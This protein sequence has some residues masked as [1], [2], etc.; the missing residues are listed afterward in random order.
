[1]AESKALFLNYPMAHYA[2]DVTIQP[3]N[4]QSGNLSESRLYSSKKNGL[5]GYRIDV[6]V[7]Q[8]GIEIGCSAHEPGSVSEFYI[9]QD[10]RNFQ[11]E[12]LIISRRNQ[13]WQMTVQWKKSFSKYGAFYQTRAIMVLRNLSR[14][15]SNQNPRNGVLSPARVFQN[16]HFSERLGPRGKLPRQD[17]LNLECRR[18]KIEMG[19]KIYDSIFMLCMCLTNWQVR[20]NTCRVED[21]RFY[22][23]IPFTGTRL[24]QVN[25]INPNAYKRSTVRKR[26]GRVDLRFHA[27]QMT[28]SEEQVVCYIA[29]IRKAS[30]LQEIL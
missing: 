23:N 14:L 29:I 9:F 17:V 28:E 21:G 24:V 11:K 8:N 26:R 22:S 27:S 10:V 13:A 19:T 1:M 16:R 18:I 25:L 30:L 15:S 2:T 7:V 20:W 6:T 4:R 5:Y 12:Q 3:S